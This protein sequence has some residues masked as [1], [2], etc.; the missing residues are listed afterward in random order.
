[1]GISPIAA[2]P[3]VLAQHGLSKEDIDVFEV[4]SLDSALRTYLTSL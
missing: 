1:M 3:K 4:S 2:V